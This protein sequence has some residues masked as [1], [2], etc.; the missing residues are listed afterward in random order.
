M[1][2]TF[3]CAK[4]WGFLTAAINIVTPSPGPD[5]V[6]NSVAYSMNSSL[7]KPLSRYLLWL[8]FTFT[9]ICEKGVQSTEVWRIR[10]L[11]R[12]LLESFS[13]K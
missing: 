5:R 6:N 10:D 13:L 2:I 9:F 8:P 1:Q 3:H 7:D 11:A 12:A 4:K